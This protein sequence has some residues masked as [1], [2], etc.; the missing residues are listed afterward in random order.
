M[1]EYDQAKLKEV[2]DAVLET[3]IGELVV[4]AIAFIYASEQVMAANPD[5][6]TVAPELKEYMLSIAD[7]GEKL[8]EDQEAAHS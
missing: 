4:L 3:P 6:D 5:P 1:A 7:L 8:F 2:R